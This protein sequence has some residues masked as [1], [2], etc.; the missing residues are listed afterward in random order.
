NTSTTI[1][2]TASIT[3]PNENDPSKPGAVYHSW[4]TNHGL[5]LM[6]IFSALAQSSDIFFYEVAGGFTNFT[7]F[8]GVTKLTHYYQLFGLGSKTGVDLP[9]ESVGR[10]P[11]PAWKQA[12][13]GSGWYTG[14]TYNIA[15]GQGD[16]LVTPLQMAAAISAVAN[17]DSLLQPY[18]V[19]KLMDSSGNTIQQMKPQTLRNAFISPA[20][21]AI[22][23]QGMLMVTQDAHGTACC[24]IK[25]E[26]PVLV[27]GKT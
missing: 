23:R 27:A 6:N 4:E 8:L 18:F 22:V 26:V 24:R 17:G 2:D 1:N 9:S 21:L 13:S 16:I 10:V 5:G 20:N 11:T 19:D 15:V 14:D 7:H 25:A 12:Y 3:I